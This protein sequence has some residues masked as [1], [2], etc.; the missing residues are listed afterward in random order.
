MHAANA[1]TRIDLAGRQRMLTQQMTKAVC[2][3]LPGKADA[4][5]R[6]QALA[7]AVTFEETLQGLRAGSPEAGLAPAQ[8]PQERAALETVQEVSAAFT[9][10]VKQL[11]SRD[12]H[13]VAMQIM[14]ARN[15]AVLARMNEAVGVIEATAGRGY[16]NPVV[17]AT[18][19][20]AGRQRMLTQRMAKNLCLIAVELDRERS[21]KDLSQSAALF[22][23]TLEGLLHGNAAA[24]LLA[25]PTPRIAA[26][27]EQVSDMW[28]SLHPAIAQVQA[29]G[30]IGEAELQDTVAQLDAILVEM[31]AA[32]TLWAAYSGSF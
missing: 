28:R 14:I 30:T 26:K 1:Q 22:S 11:A 15:L 10:S 7:A 17:A 18:I 25:P 19:N 23:E 31:N 12:L 5:W 21:L 6:E 9:A 8:T 2:L 13:T 29:Q 4:Q 20:Q 32:V 3:A 24:N 27:L 16:S